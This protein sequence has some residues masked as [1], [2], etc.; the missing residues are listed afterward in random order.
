MRLADLQLAQD[1]N[2]AL[3]RLDDI[4]G[5]AELRTDAGELTL[6]AEETADFVEWKRQR[7][8][9]QLRA[10]GI[11]PDGA[12]PEP[13]VTQPEIT[14]E[15]AAPRRSGTAVGA[16]VPP[17]PATIDEARAIARERLLGPILKDN[18]R[19]LSN[20]PMILR[21]WQEEIDKYAEKRAADIEAL[22]QE[23]LRG[24]QDSVCSE[25]DEPATTVIAGSPYC[26]AHA[27]TAP[28]LAPP[29][30]L[31]LVHSA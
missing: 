27:K 15:R 30:H 11:E 4:A 23:I 26:T 22:A 19:P 3:L 16:A 1:L 24:P 28:R 29:D 7:I 17:R 12:A 13:Q 21:E 9:Q 25:C 31:A 20:D 2:A 18:K 14:R 10:L 5:P 6:E 8:Y